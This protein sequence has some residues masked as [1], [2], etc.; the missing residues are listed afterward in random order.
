MQRSTD[1]KKSVRLAV[2]TIFISLFLCSS[3]ALALQTDQFPDALPSL[4]LAH[5]QFEPLL[6]RPHQ[7]SDET[8]QNRVDL[9][10]TEAWL[11]CE[12]NGC[13]HHEDCALEVYY[14]LSSALRSAQGIGARI[15]CRVR[16]D[17]TTSHGYELQSE[18]CSK[19]ETHRLYHS[20]RVESSIIVDFR[21]S[22]YEQVVD[23]RVGSI[24]CSIEQAHI[25]EPRMT[26]FPVN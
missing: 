2:T 5:S 12:D 21:F 9:Q 7:P 18:R 19:S 1:K 24:Q 6:P 15:S 17:Y 20:D 10:V 16:L 26:A 13:S 4:Q 8:G 14:R 23:V 25:L 3:P 22:S 11:H